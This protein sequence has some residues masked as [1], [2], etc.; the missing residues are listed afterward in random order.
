MSTPAFNPSLLTGTGVR[1][2]TDPRL[3]PFIV[4]NIFG[5]GQSGK[6]D[7]A[8]QFRPVLHHLFGAPQEAE[9]AV[10]RNK[11]KGPYYQA[12]Y[13]GEV[14]LS[15]HG[16]NEKE[17]SAF[18]RPQ[19]DR[20]SADLAAGIKAG[21]RNFVIDKGNEL[22]ESIVYAHFGKL[23]GVTPAVRFR[24]P[25]AEYERLIRSVVMAKRNLF[26]IH[27]DEDEWESY[28]EKDKEG[29]L[30][31]KRKT[32]GR[33][34]CKSNDKIDYMV[35]VS[36]R[37]F[38]VP[39]PDQKVGGVLFRLQFTE[40]RP[41]PELIGKLFDPSEGWLSYAMLVKPQVPVEAWL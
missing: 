35:D 24:E 18:Y 9:A 17:I 1:A 29:V 13:A 19:V 28:W 23:V 12:V 38:K 3:E 33:R 7:F 31:E 15:L 20:F 10:L 22:W 32:T 25:N 39:N 40:C 5:P 36:L 6:S 14:P 11:E 34:I 4:T 16:K 2:V 27:E 30:K 41:R 8:M 37:A 21:F 26:L